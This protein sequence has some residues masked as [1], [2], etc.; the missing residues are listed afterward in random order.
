MARRPTTRKGISLNP[1][2]QALRRRFPARGK[3]PRARLTSSKL[4]DQVAEAL[5]RE[6][7]GCC[8]DRGERDARYWEQFCD[9]GRTA[10]HAYL[11]ALEEAGYRIVSPNEDN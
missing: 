4:V 11:D 5:C 8:T 3:V 2:P 7:E 10:I 1:V 9:E 6:W